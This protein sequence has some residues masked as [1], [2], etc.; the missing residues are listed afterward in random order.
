M[1]KY[2]RYAMYLRKSRAD[3]ELEALG[4]GE[5][6]ARHKEILFDVARRHDIFPEQITVYQEVVSGESISAR[7][8]MQRLLND[9]YL[10]CYKGVLVME[11]ERLARGNTKDQGEV[12][13]AFQYSGTHIITPI[14][15]YD[16]LNE[17]DQEY[18]EFGLFMSRRE[19]KTIKRRMEAGRIQSFR[20]G[21][22]VGSV[23]PYGYNAERIN[24][25]ERVLVEN[26]EEGRIVRLVFDWFTEERLTPGQIAKRL[27]E[28]S[29]PT[30]I[31]NA[32]WNRGTIADML[33]NVHYI[34]KVRWNRCRRTKEY[35]VKTGKLSKTKRRLTPDDYQVFEGKHKALVSEEQ[36]NKAQTLFTGNAPVAA[37][38]YL[39]N[40]FSGLI[41]CEAC[42]KT[43]SLQTF[44]SRSGTA[45]RYCHRG[46]GCGVKSCSVSAF[47]AAFIQAI[48]GYISDFEIKMSDESDVAEKARRA[49]AVA[50]IESEL[51]KQ[52]R[53]KQRLFDSW[54]ADDGT[55]TR[56]EFIERKQLYTETIEAL[57]KQL[58][59][60]K[61]AMSETVDYSEKITTLHNLIEIVTDENTDA[62]VKNDFLRDNIE[63]IK[64]NVI[65]LG[66]GKGAK[67]VLDVYLKY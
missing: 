60:A 51:A 2:A 40:P 35:D 29:I 67:P 52:E 20:E 47:N 4:E 27:T 41:K 54:E 26:P 62:K 21:N 6:L 10:K 50:A 25:K 17:F 23:P 37:N 44:P 49:E 16:P 7:P 55:Y 30:R 18:F 19:Y 9:L 3:I 8:E 32:E 1:E 48:K 43:I 64:Y 36:F 33:Q 63:L 57:K 45:P 61:D 38:S 65:D 42:G 14:K 5:T 39:C 24:K 13:D 31:G 28:M 59:E 53:K 56:D 58:R 11:V 46:N 22:Y 12:S 34:G 15:E 66:R